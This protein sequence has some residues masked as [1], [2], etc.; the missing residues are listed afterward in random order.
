MLSRLSPSIYPEYSRVYQLMMGR[1]QETGYR[2][3]TD[4]NVL[5]INDDDSQHQL[6]TLETP[7]GIIQAGFPPSSK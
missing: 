7:N 4:T 6:L 3:L 1:T 5:A 2:Q